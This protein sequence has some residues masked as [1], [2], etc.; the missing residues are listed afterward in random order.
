MVARRRGDVGRSA[1]LGRLTGGAPR[2]ALAEGETGGPDGTSTFVLVANTS[3]AAGSIRLTLAL[4][5]GATAVREFP[6]AGHAR[7][8]IDIGADFPDTT[9]R[10]YG[11]LVESAGPTPLDLVV[12]RSMYSNSG[13][14]PW[15][16][17][18]CAPARRL[19]AESSDGA[20]PLPL[21]TLSAQRYAA[22]SG[23]LIGAFGFDP[24]PTAPARS[25]STTRCSGAPPRRT[26]CP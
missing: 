6:I 21:I 10:R 2:W 5:N 26:T 25:R 13:G 19:P 9:G 11:T 7:S 14:V 1:R 8:T 4:E 18:T 16:A 24:R 17:G 20:T 15:A 23:T 22:E 12:E 3:A